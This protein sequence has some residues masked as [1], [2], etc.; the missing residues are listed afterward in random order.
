MTPRATELDAG[1][2]RDTNNLVA[3][4]PTFRAEQDLDGSLAALAETAQDNLELVHVAVPVTLVELV[5]DVG[6]ELVGSVIRAAL[7]LLEAE[8]AG[9][10]ADNGVAVGLGDGDVGVVF[11]RVDVKVEGLGDGTPFWIP[12][13]VAEDRVL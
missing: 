5:H 11:V 1:I 12:A 6:D 4:Q 9:A 13:R 8:V 2:V 10:H 7:R 3:E